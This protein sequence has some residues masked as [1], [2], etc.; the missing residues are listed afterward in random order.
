MMDINNLLSGQR[1]TELYIRL[2]HNLHPELR[3]QFDYNYFQPF[4]YEAARSHCFWPV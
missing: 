1:T 2:H 3:S 4:G